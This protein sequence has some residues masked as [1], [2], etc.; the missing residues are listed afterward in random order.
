[1]PV[2]LRIINEPKTN[3]IKKFFKIFIP[4]RPKVEE[5]EVEGINLKNITYCK[6]NSKIPWKRIS[7]IIKEDSKY[8]LC[9]KSI[10]LPAIYGVYRFTSNELYR[11]LCKNAVIS[12]LDNLRLN[13][14]KI[15]IALYDPRAAYSDLLEILLKYSSQVA[16]ISNHIEFYENKSTRLMKDYDAAILVSDNIS[17]LDGNHLVVAPDKVRVNL[18]LSSNTVLFTAEKPGLNLDCT[19]ISG[20]KVN[21]PIKYKK[22]IPEDMEDEYFLSY[23]YLENKI[24]ELASLIP[25]YC[26]L[27]KGVKTINEIS[28]ELDCYCSLEKDLEENLEEDLEE[29]PSPTSL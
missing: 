24:Y 21:T 12:V 5:L 6:R 4:N 10:K 23:L 27:E 2:V 15:N 8:V 22:L 20:Y 19:V 28:E 29:D 18:G 1:M 25:I 26:V 7:K 14:S 13:S 9:D 16:V 3:A 11:H 17:L